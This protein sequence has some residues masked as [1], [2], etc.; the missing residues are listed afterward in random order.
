M[1]MFLPLFVCL[2]AGRLVCFSEGFTQLLIDEIFRTYFGTD[3]SSNKK[4]TDDIVFASDLDHGT[5]DI[6]FL[7]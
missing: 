6:N 5:Y 3:V 4:T 1:V 2:F 7:K